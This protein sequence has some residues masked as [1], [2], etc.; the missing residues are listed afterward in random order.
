MTRRKKIGVVGVPGSWSSEE[1]A[2]AVARVTGYRLLI[3]MA[4]VRFDLTDGRAFYEGLDIAT[5]DALVVK[6]VGPVYGPDLI[7]R[8]ESLRFLSE[9]GTPIFSR[10]GATLRLLDRLACTVTLA[11]NG[12]PMPDTA[13]TEDPGEARAVVSRFGK[14]VFKPLFSTKAR[15]MTVIPDGP[16]AATGIATFK[17][18]GNRVMYI[19]KMIDIPGKDLGV[20]FMGG[21]YYATYARRGSGASWNTTTANG[22]KYEAYDPPQE[23]VDL[24]ARAQAPFGLDFTCV[25]VVET[26][27]GPKVF[28]VSAFGGFRGLRD[29]NGK[30]A[31]A[32]YAAYILKR[33]KNS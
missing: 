14:A 12:I 6:K 18:A 4:R 11:A 16:A 31:A 5:L 9:R 15:G 8:L 24:A 13:V 21:E 29:G 33:L 32:D 25:D 30:N 17:A 10:P 2:D 1:L 22:G 27:D 26:A 19:Q 3:D 20:V 23:V 28:E 7:D